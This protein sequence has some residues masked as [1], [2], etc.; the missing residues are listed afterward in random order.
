MEEET[1]EVLDSQTAETKSEPTEIEN[2]LIL[3]SSKTLDKY[4]K[5]TL[6]EVVE[7]LEN[8]N[9]LV[10]NEGDETYRW[11]IPK[12]TFLSA[13][14]KFEV[15]PKHVCKDKCGSC[16]FEYQERSVV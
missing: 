7:V 2:E 8:G 14:D 6:I 5:N 16:E 9:V 11:E 1:K 4:K 12:E 15:G 13:Y 3:V 10:Q